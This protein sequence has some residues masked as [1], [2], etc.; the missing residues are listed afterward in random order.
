MNMSA[1]MT[2]AM[3]LIYVA[4]AGNELIG[5]RWANGLIYVGYVVANCGLLA[6]VAGYG[7]KP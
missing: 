4:A 1:W 6:I 3:T 2:A 5:Q 7:A